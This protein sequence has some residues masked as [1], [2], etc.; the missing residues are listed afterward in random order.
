LHCHSRFSSATLGAW[1]NPRYPKS[2]KKSPSTTAWHFTGAPLLD[3][4]T[5]KW[6]KK[7]VS[8]ILSTAGVVLAGVKTNLQPWWI[9]TAAC[10]ASALIWM[11][12]S[13]LSMGHRGELHPSA[14]APP[15]ARDALPS[16]TVRIGSAIIAPDEPAEGDSLKDAP[17]LL[18]SYR[19]TPGGK[20]HLI[21][22]NE[23]GRTALVQR[24]GAI[25]GT[26]TFA[27]YYGMTVVPSTPHVAMREPVSCDLFG[28][29]NPY[30][31]GTHPLEDVLRNFSRE[32][33]AS[34]VV[35]FNDA[36]GRQFSQQFRLKREA[37]DSV[38]FN[39]DPVVIRG[40]V[41]V[42]PTGRQDLAALHFK[43]KLLRDAKGRLE[44]AGRLL[45]LAEQ[46][47]LLMEYLGNIL[48]ENDA[49]KAKGIDLSKPLHEAV[50]VGE[51]EDAMNKYKLK[52][53]SFRDRYNMHQ[54]EVC[55]SSGE[56]NP[57]G[58]P[59]QIPNELEKDEILAA[60]A[61]HANSLKRAAVNLESPYQS[62]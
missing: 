56:S 44:Q 55:A 27:A 14:V 57:F 15:A 26:E 51:G 10:E 1:W 53:T 17:A 12:W 37:N 59:P 34:V 5:D 50:F 40:Q 24:I 19:R 43:L 45:H 11:I 28:V 20:S 39:P 8:V 52:M 41:A 9:V 4:L 33:S 35:D 46:A 48:K 54:R 61:K 3:A 22:S 36:D 16:P 47:E 32:G 31:G 21:L 23:K 6:K 2:A 58:L 13:F 38:I 49:D 29:A 18:L 25:H 62:I 60:L 7:A 42:P 30:E